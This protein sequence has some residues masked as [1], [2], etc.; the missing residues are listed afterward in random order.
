VLLSP[1]YD[2]A[3]VLAVEARTPGPHP[4]L[5]QRDRLGAQLRE[6]APDE[7]RAPSRCDAWTVQD[8]ITHLNTTNGFWTVSM[9]QALAGEPTRLLTTFDPVATPAQLVEVSRGVDPDAT[10]AT[11]L[12]GVA[13]LRSV[14]DG[15]TERQ[16][17]EVIGEAPPGH[18]PLRLVADHALWDCW[19]HERDVLL[20]LGR[21]AHED[22]DEILTSLR[23]AAGLGRGFVLQQEAGASAGGAV[24]L[25]VTGPD[26]RLVVDAGE[27]QVRVHDGPAPRGARSVELPAVALL[28]MLSMREVGQPV[29][30]A[31]R[32]LTAGLA[33]VFDQTEISEPS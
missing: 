30:E 11:Y 16:W 26:A 6:L 22:P 8:V 29:P 4:V 21:P 33:T 9:G 25:L 12:E 31:V 19:V 28:E 1:R 24:E 3:P 10:L 32:W 18:L 17:D 20:P 13:D 2:A 7:W 5:Q 15:L 14:V 23:Y 27:E